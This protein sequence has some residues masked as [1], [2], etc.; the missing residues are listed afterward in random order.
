[1]NKTEQAEQAIFSL[2]KQLCLTGLGVGTIGGAW[3]AYHSSD[4]Q[5]MIATMHPFFWVLVVVLPIAIIVVLVS[6]WQTW[7]NLLK[8]NITEAL[9]FFIGANLIGA[10]AA[11]LIFLIPTFSF[12][13]I[14]Q[15][16]EPDQMRVALFNTFGWQHLGIV[17]G[18]AGITAC[19]MAA[20][21]YWQVNKPTE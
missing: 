12:P 21:L 5:T 18:V 6:H 16:L 8:R 11:S 13:Y 9:V 10:T 4:S 1:M 3:G 20:W 7:H 17:V 14:F 19:G 2:L 15:N